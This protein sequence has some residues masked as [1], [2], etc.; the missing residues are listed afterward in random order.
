MKQGHLSGYFSKLAVKRLTEVEVNSAVSSQREFN[1]VAALK[2]LFPG[3]EKVQM[4]AFFLWL[5][6]DEVRSSEGSLTWYDA[7][8]RHEKRSEYRLYFQAGDTLSRARAGDV[9][10]VALK[11]EGGAV[12]IVSHPDTTA[13]RQILWLFGIADPLSE[14]V[15]V[16]G[17]EGSRDVELNFVA[18][19]VL[20]LIGV[21]VWTPDEDDLQQMLKRFG[22]TFPASREFS[23]WARSRSKRVSVLDDPDHALMT[24]LEKEE[25]LFKTLERH[26]VGHRLVQGFAPGG[27]PDVDAFVKYSLGVQNRRKS[28]AGLALEN[29]LEEIFSQCRLSFTRGAVTERGN[30]PDFVFPGQ[31]AYLDSSF[32]SEQLVMLAA[33]ASC[34][35]RWRQILNEAARIP[36][37]H[38]LTL[39]PGVSS[40][41]TTDMRRSGVR[42]VLPRQIHPSYLAE[43]LREILDLAAF[44]GSVRELNDKGAL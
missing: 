8:E 31:A 27:T 6:E 33:K 7:R 1:G 11:K 14:N 44:I 9:L 20:E 2:K 24:W 19:N 36:S 16:I 41:Q 15:S 21:D 25:Q 3:N 22:G 23:A 29:H 18:R 13:F 5:G 43:Q 37:K 42:L 34:K 10:L 12:F 28:R 4:A 32:P 39:E 17:I 26:V 40:A 35:D 38:L 30:S